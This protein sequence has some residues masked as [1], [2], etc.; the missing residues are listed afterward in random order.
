MPKDFDSR[1]YH[2]PTYTPIFS[3]SHFQISD[4]PA[5]IS[6]DMSGVEALAAFGVACNVFQT[7][8][9][10]RETISLI[11]AIYQTGSF[12]PTLSDQAK[13]LDDACSELQSLQPLSNPTRDQK[14]LFEVTT[15]CLSISKDL[16]DE[17]KF[18]SDN[19]AKGKLTATLKVATKTAW[20]KRRLNTLERKLGEAEKK[21]QDGLLVR[22]W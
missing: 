5:S 18:I 9:F 2:T 22:I 16:Q 19:G 1:R 21:M 17:I 14:R 4:H 12:D 15:N 11:K 3:S 13:F 7:I 8:G 6:F 10:G 20:R